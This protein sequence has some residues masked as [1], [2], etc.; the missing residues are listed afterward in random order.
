V[1]SL[2]LNVEQGIDADLDPGATHDLI[3]EPLLVGALDAAELPPEF[4]FVA[5][6]T[7]L[8]SSSR[9]FSQAEPASPSGART[10]RDSIAS[11]S[12]ARH[13][14]GHVDEPVGIQFG[15]AGEDMLAHQMR[16][17]F[18]HPLTRWLPITARCAMRTRRSPS[19][20]MMDRRRLRSISAG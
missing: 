9:S 17:E 6:P 1:D 16:M 8:P 19:S 12:A 14:V 11:A 3:S 13:A 10:G 18:R 5:A 20:S 4:R 15:E 7:S 2:Y